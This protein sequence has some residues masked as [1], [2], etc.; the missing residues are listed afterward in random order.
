MKK[1]KQPLPS[2]ETYLTESERTS[3][4]RLVEAGNFVRAFN[5]VNDELRIRATLEAIQRGMRE[6]IANELA[7]KPEDYQ[8]GIQSAVALCLDDIVLCS[9]AMHPDNLARAQK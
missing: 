8:R 4:S 7:S 6:N 9:L 2:G 1:P 5:V 3:I